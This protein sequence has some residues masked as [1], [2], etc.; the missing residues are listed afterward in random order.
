VFSQASCS[1]GLNSPEIIVYSPSSGSSYQSW[2]AH[3]FLQSE[4]GSAKW[5]KGINIVKANI[6]NAVTFTNQR[7]YIRHTTS[8]SYPDATYPGTSGFTQVYNGSYVMTCCGSQTI[9]VTFSP[10][11]YYNGTD[12]LEILFEN[13]SNIE[14]QNNTNDPWFRRTNASSA[15]NRT[16][17][18]NSSTSGVFPGSSGAVRRDFIPG[19]GLGTSCQPFT[20][21]IELVS[22]S[23]KYEEGGVILN[24]VTASETNNDFFTIERS[25]DTKEFIE[26]SQIK[27]AGNSNSEQKYTYTDPTPHT[28][29]NYYRLKQTDFDGNYEYSSIVSVYPEKNNSSFRISAY[30]KENNI[31]IMVIND[32]E[33]EQL[34]SLLISDIQGKLMTQNK[35]NCLSGSNSFTIQTPQKIKTGIYLIQLI[36]PVSA[37]SKKLIF[38]E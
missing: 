18:N 20:L 24:W 4:V 22:F 25:A 11:F 6:G 27:G 23:G 34:I 15:T 17:L 9:A 12:N 35:Y 30:K 38:E 21:P 33:E 8:S 14:S 7:I 26:I 3:V 10:E 32:T 16:K 29:I 2:S 31:H 28:G 37:Y 19:I 1:S 36:S 5:I 13:R